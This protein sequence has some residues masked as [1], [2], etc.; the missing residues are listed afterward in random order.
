M[1]GA[2]FINLIAHFTEHLLCNMS[3]SEKPGRRKTWEKD[4]LGFNHLEIWIPLSVPSLY[5]F[6]PLH[7]LFWFPHKWNICVLIDRLNALVPGPLHMAVY[8]TCIAL[9]SQKLPE[10][11]K[12]LTS[13]QNKAFTVGGGPSWE[14]SGHKELAEF[15]ETEYFKGP[16]CFGGEHWLWSQ[17]ACLGSNP[18]F[19]IC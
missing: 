1:L 5:Q 14:D 6:G 17:T 15:N 11:E 18:C 8:K 10:E 13:T 19:V 3:C 9:S 4:S 12:G 16:L 2:R 7:D